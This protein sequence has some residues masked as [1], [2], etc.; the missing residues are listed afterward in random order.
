M[1]GLE[2]RL[3]RL[4]ITE[5]GGLP[6]ISVDLD[7]RLRR[8]G[9]GEPESQPGEFSKGLS[10]GLLQTRALFHGAGAA[11]GDITGADEFTAQRIADYQR[12]TQEAQQYAAE[13]PSWDQIDTP[14][15]FVSWAASVLG[16]QVPVIA[17]VLLT[18]GA[19]SILGLAAKKG[20]EK[21]ALNFLG[22]KMAQWGAVGGITAGA[23]ALETGGITGE[24]IEE[25]LPLEGGSALAFGTAAG[26]LEA[27]L[28]IAAMSYFRVGAPTASKLMGNYKQALA[29]MTR[30]KRMGAVGAT[31]AFTEASTE[32]MQEAL[33]IAARKTVDE[34][35][36][37]L[38]DEAKARLLDSGITGGFVGFVFGGAGGFFRPRADGTTQPEPDIGGQGTETET[39]PETPPAA[40]ITPEQPPQGTEEPL[41][42][43]DPTKL[44]PTAREDFAA[45]AEK[46]NAQ[47]DE[48]PS[49]SPETPV[50]EA[51]KVKALSNSSAQTVD[52][53]MPMESLTLTTASELSAEQK[54]ADFEVAK[55]K[56]RRELANLKQNLGQYQ[57][58][59]ND[60]VFRTLWDIRQ[61]LLSAQE[62][63]AKTGTLKPT[64]TASIKK[65]ETKMTKIAEKLGVQSPG[66][67]DT[68]TSDVV[69][70]KDAALSPG[71]KRF[72]AKLRRKEEM[73]GLSELEYEK[74][75]RLETKAK[76]GDQIQKA[77]DQESA[78]LELEAEAEAL[79]ETERDARFI[80]KVRKERE[81]DFRDRLK[82]LQG[83]PSFTQ[84]G[85]AQ[86]ILGRGFTRKQ[87]LS[88]IE[89]VRVKDEGNIV[90]LDH[91][92][93]MDNIELASTIRARDAMS[94][95]TT[96]GLHI[97]KADGSRGTSYFF[98]SEI[99]SEEQAISMYLHEVVG[100]GG[101]RSLG[102]TAYR[103]II[104]LVKK[105]QKEAMEQRALERDQLEAM[106]SNPKVADLMAEEVIAHAAENPSA[107]NMSFLKK[108]Y[109]LVRNALRRMGLTLRLNDTDISFI[110]QG[111]R[112][113]LN[114]AATFEMANPLE[115]AQ[116]QQGGK[117][118]GVTYTDHFGTERT[119]TRYRKDG[120]Y[121]DDAAWER[122]LKTG[123]ELVA[124]YKTEIKESKENIKRW[125]E[126]WDAVK[127]YVAY[128]K[129]DKALEVEVVKDR[130]RF[131]NTKDAEMAEAYNDSIAMADGYLTDSEGREA[132][133]VNA[134]FSSQVS[135]WEEQ[136]R[137]LERLLDRYSRQLAADEKLAIPDVA[138]GVF[139]LS[140][141]AKNAKS[142]GASQDIV[143]EIDRFSSLWKAKVFTRILTLEQLAKTYNL[144]EVKKYID[145]VTNWFGAKSAVI[146]KTDSL[147]QEWNKGGKDFSNKVGRALFEITA[148]SDANAAAG[149][150][151]KVSA[152]DRARIYQR[153]GVTG[154]EI[155][156]VNE[157]VDKVLTQLKDVIK[158]V[159]R[160]RLVEQASR[161]VAN[162]DP[163]NIE[164]MTDAW[165]AA[166]PESVDPTLPHIIERRQN[167]L[168]GYQLTPEE[169]ETLFAAW[170][171]TTEEFHTLKRRDYFPYKRFGK[172]TITVVAPH[173]I[174]Y[175]GKTYKAGDLI[176]FATAENAREQN[177][178]ADIDEIK[179]LQRHG[180]HM[181]KGI[182]DEAVKDF[183]GIPPSLFESMR[184]KMGLTEAQ[185]NQLKKISLAMTPGR[186]F[187][188]HMVGRRGIDGMSSDAQRVFT[189]YMQ[190][191]ANHMARIRYQRE[192][193]AA[194]KEL[195]HRVG[196]T[197]EEM[198]ALAFGGDTRGFDE[199]R[200]ALKRHE[201][202]ILYPKDEWAF[203][204]S[205]GFMFYLGFNVKSALVNFSQVPLVTFPYLSN[206][207]GSVRAM[208]ALT[209]AIPKAWKGFNINPEN[210][211]NI[212]LS[213]ELDDLIARGIRDG[214][215]EESMAVE[216]A[217]AS[218][219]SGLARAMG[220]TKAQ[221]FASRL[222]YYGATPFR[223]TEKASRRV[224]FIA[225]VE[226][227][228]EN[229]PG[230]MEGAFIAGRDAVRSTMF[231]YAKWN[232]P[233]FM[234]GKKSVFF[235]FWTFMQHMAFV[236]FGGEGA[237]V[238]IGV[239]LLLLFTAGLQGLPFAENLMDIIDWGGS[240]VREA[241]GLKN[242]RV[243]T[244][245]Y[246]RSQL[247]E[248]MSWLSE[249]PDLM[250]HGMS[251]Y[252]GLGPLHLFSMIGAPI[253]HVDLSGSLSMGRPVPG[254][255]EMFGAGKPDEKLGRTLAAMGGAVFGIPYAVYKTLEDD[256]PDSWKR[257]ERMMPSALK[258]ANKALRM[259]TRGAEE[260]RGGGQVAEFNPNN[261]SHMAELVAQGLGFTPTRLNE[262]YELRA[263]QEDMKEYIMTRRNLL[264]NQMAHAYRI[265]DREAIA[266]IRKSI[267]IFNAGVPDRR[268]RISGKTLRRSLRERKRRIRSRELGRPV[269]RG[270]R[271]EYRRIEELFPTV[272]L[273]K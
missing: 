156:A 270:L 244:R 184:E 94:G 167:L 31:A 22:Q 65:L 43:P 60:A 234:R 246:L 88:A 111:L 126:A 122:H 189:S 79:T 112:D 188:K 50:Q 109:A 38:G 54:I 98:L 182:L 137:Q 176:Y 228:L 14:G 66:F 46:F 100:H 171:N 213:R 127:R 204:R 76:G 33:A 37:S 245:E 195:D 36:D 41:A 69:R 187:V 56:A 161:L 162:I 15:Q 266:D 119:R 136:L 26:S 145:V 254:T 83:D 32:V 210:R 131:A 1:S 231:E 217:E 70:Q 207:Y 74:L 154:D 121:I 115:A 153:I 102:N 249:N 258:G 192:M 218:Q 141:A 3:N 13:V 142:L 268:L 151:P 237:K 273:P 5:D 253:P 216:V 205:W 44:T 99:T 20:L 120:S 24:R 160:T 34:E 117:S 214:F 116:A 93:E 96:Q 236:L 103:S 72:L 118:Q 155:N 181:T 128:R 7:A 232:R 10:R 28:P 132:G 261:T 19:G 27:L 157:M 144:P 105:S 194:R 198:G 80:E 262:R 25:G 63:W 248:H 227:H 48:T 59:R 257:W 146:A 183:V 179:T 166:G 235:L 125:R 67:L 106:K 164:V 271:K 225:S 158:G 21:T 219:G 224:A 148:Q 81:R 101:L 143:E 256:N 199:I 196:V 91:I 243:N 215:L 222:V 221:R 9:I 177:L 133:P 62:S 211:S 8:L 212:H 150:D 197:D 238:A 191:A 90:I 230:D 52:L 172:Y 138:Q 53:D 95:F 239:W 134:I 209:K 201:D 84:G 264:L 247:K 12:L 203:L 108:L 202:Y 168:E 6:D 175:Q 55:A 165:V 92:A 85:Y 49:T 58:L 206:Q 61:G 208:S 68:P 185:E 147:L 113:H 255:Q 135:K 152:P 82:A 39:T 139:G 233:E 265:N 200:N 18:G 123:R 71:E 241:L 260:F 269:E 107:Y 220:S 40:P 42:P 259:G 263:F 45:A 159:E 75:E 64:A 129:G 16:E 272:E 47:L 73:E 149:H 17:S 251:R 89:K 178:L 193:A 229:N 87:F 169:H 226:L 23:S 110:L 11:L 30:P 173:E 78:A 57:T 140:R 4:G 35:Y 86:T 242:S 77:A 124:S 252:Y 2:D 240:N 180:F 223:L 163:A 114:G 51:K 190:S 104:N 170:Q 97:P 130:M 267:K 186:G 29:K 250:M 174:N